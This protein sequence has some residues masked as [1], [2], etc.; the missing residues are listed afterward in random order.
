MSRRVTLKQIAD[1]LGYSKNTISLALRNSPQIP[2][3][4]REKI[5][6]AA[7]EMGYQ[8]NAVI[9]HLMAQLRSSQSPRFQAKLALVNANE[10]PTAFQD[11]PTIPTYVEGCERRAA[12][13]GY[14]FD[15]FWLHEPEL[16]AHSFIRILKTRNI[17]G[18]ILAGLMDTAELP[19]R[20][21]SVWP[22]FACAVTGV[23]TLNPT[24][25]YC[26]VDHHDLT[27]QAFQQALRLGYRRPGLALDHVIDDLVERRFSAGYLIGQSH[28]D[29]ADRISPFLQYRA[30]QSDLSVF[31]NWVRKERPDVV[32]T[33]YHSVVRWLQDL[34]LRIPED[35]GVIQLE[36]RASHPEIAGMHQHNDVTGEAVVDMVISQ[37]HNNE[38]GAPEFPR[39]T[40][41]G[42]TWV[43]GSSV[44]SGAA[45]RR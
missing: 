28:L 29:P 2:S 25:S 9:S 23:R 39:S 36:W 11:H 26:C 27:L 8:P 30:A 14:A 24:L 19:A 41:V 40:Y 31:A 7:K 34:G 10:S 3:A 6:R 37:I 44:R 18:V 16:S 43:D 12:Q 32:F 17:Q 33:L 21:A 38:R 4:T 13:R 1:K 35:I 42:A 45:K 15:R 22:H 20:L 5:R